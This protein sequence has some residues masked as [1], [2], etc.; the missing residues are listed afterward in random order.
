MM[1]MMLFV[2]ATNNNTTENEI[3][4]VPRLYQNEIIVRGFPAESY[5]N[6]GNNDNNDLDNDDNDL[7]D[8]DDLDNDDNDLDDDDDKISVSTILNSNDSRYSFR[9]DDGSDQFQISIQTNNLRKGKKPKKKKNSKKKKGRKHCYKS[10][11]FCTDN[12]RC[13]THVSADEV[14][15]CDRS[16]R[17]GN[18]PQTCFKSV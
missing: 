6:T 18:V 12:K 13:C 14:W 16:T 9:N 10:Q 1:M 2:N 4:D 15:C 8:D 3:Q 11:L 5:N 7:D 17:C